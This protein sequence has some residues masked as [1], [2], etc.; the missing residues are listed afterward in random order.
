MSVLHHMYFVPQ[1]LKFEL[2]MLDSSILNPELVLLLIQAPLLLV[3]RLLKKLN[4]LFTL[5][6]V[7]SLRPLVHKTHVFELL[8]TTRW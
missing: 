3:D 6:V 2:Q 1:L 8:E 5:R 7:V 4:F